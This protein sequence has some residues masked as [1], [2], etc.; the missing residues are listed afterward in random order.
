MQDRVPKSINLDDSA[1]TTTV[2]F[3]A[4]SSKSTSCY[5][6]PIPYDG[7]YADSHGALDIETGKGLFVC[8]MEVY[9]VKYPF[10]KI[11]STR[12]RTLHVP[13]SWVDRQW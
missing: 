4:H 12:V 5:D 6:C 8:D 1:V 11:Q 3:N 7:V 2:F 10:R 13:V 9:N